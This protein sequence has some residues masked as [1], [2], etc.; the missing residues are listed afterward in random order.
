MENYKTSAS[1]ISLDNIDWSIPVDHGEGQKCSG[2]GRPL[3]WYGE[4]SDG[5]IISS[6]WHR[7][8]YADNSYI[9]GLCNKCCQEHLA[10]I[11]KT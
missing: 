5:V 4:L 10:N 3:Y 8:L 11:N 6:G 2:C 9:H 7:H 1:S